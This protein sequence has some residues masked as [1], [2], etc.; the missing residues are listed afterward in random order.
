ME[1]LAY[2]AGVIVAVTGA[3]FAL[4][5]VAAGMRKTGKRWED[6]LDDWHG[7]PAR[8]GRPAIPGVMERMVDLET[9]LQVVRHELFPNSGAS[10]RDALDRLEHELSLLKKPVQTMADSLDTTR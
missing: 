7:T 10:V 9:G 3:L 5:R 8:P 6:F 1:V 2:I 4:T